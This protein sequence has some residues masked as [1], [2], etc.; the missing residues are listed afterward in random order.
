M[1]DEHH[2]PVHHRSGANTFVRTLAAS[3]PRLA[4]ALLL[5]FGCLT[6]AARADL[7]A[8]HSFYVELD[9]SPGAKLPRSFQGRFEFVRVPGNERLRIRSEDARVCFTEA[10]CLEPN[11][12]VRG[13]TEHRLSRTGNAILLRLFA[14]RPG[15]PVVIH[16]EDNPDGQRALLHS[17]LELYEPVGNVAVGGKMIGDFRLWGSWGTARAGR[18]P[19]ND[20]WKTWLPVDRPLHFDRDL[21]GDVH[22]TVEDDGD[23]FVRYEA[24]AS[25]SCPQMEGARAVCERLRSLGIGGTVFSL[26][27]EWSFDE[28]NEGTVNDLVAL[29]AAG[30]WGEN[31]LE[32]ELGVRGIESD[33][34]RLPFARLRAADLSTVQARLVDPAENESPVSPPNVGPTLGQ[35]LPRPHATQLVHRTGGLRMELTLEQYE[36]HL[37]DTLGGTLL[38]H[39]EDCPTGS[40]HILSSVCRWASDVQPAQIDLALEKEV[41]QSGDSRGTVSWVGTGTPYHPAARAS[42]AIEVR[43]GPNLGDRRVVYLRHG[44]RKDSLVFA[45]VPDASAPDA[46]LAPSAFDLGGRWLV[47]ASDPDLDFALG[48]RDLGGGRLSVAVRARN[49]V[50]GQIEAIAVPDRRGSCFYYGDECFEVVRDVKGTVDVLGAVGF[51]L[52]DPDGRRIVVRSTQST[53]PRLDAGANSASM[54]LRAMRD[55][56]SGRDTLV[57]RRFGRSATGLAGTYRTTEGELVLTERALK[58]PDGSVA[59]AGLD[60]ER[61][62]AI[63]I[64]PQRTIGVR[65]IELS[66]NGA[67]APDVLIEMFRTSETLGE[68]GERW[69]AK[70]TGGLALPILTDA[71][72]QRFASFLTPAQ[73]DWLQFR[74]DDRPGLEPWRVADIDRLDQPAGS[75]SDS[76]ACRFYPNQNGYP[77]L[78]CQCRDD[79]GGGR[80]LFTDPDA[81]AIDP[82]L[83]GGERLHNRNGEVHC[84]RPPRFMATLGGAC[85][86]VNLYRA[87][88]NAPNELRALCEIEHTLPSRSRQSTLLSPEGCRAVVVENARLVCRHSEGI[89][90]TTRVDAARAR[91]TEVADEVRQ[92]F[93]P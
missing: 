2:R 14:N 52:R 50:E 47:N 74:L 25:R 45:A 38:V 44:G 51:V 37:Q 53:T 11:Q 64:D 9:E 84:R 78:T 72:W 91:A 46:G 30:G 71:G 36:A 35:T 40:A 32:I 21:A 58:L 80:G 57:A 65:L 26:A 1:I 86:Q 5:T 66:V 18:V 23:V 8:A 16:L 69:T 75:Y 42:D 27:P 29:R 34:R 79:R 92:P 82:V 88:R 73:H 7:E 41:A 10:L 90:S 31:A 12:W 83:C 49:L 22:V 33:D 17:D 89:E 77:V 55:D 68:P 70:R 61:A 60:E 85:S 62:R 3:I 54:Q 56:V 28:P 13:E 63:V 81:K 87:H 39:A 48:I 19:A 15:G 93:R 6:S 4:V 67:V 76:C 24:D 20:A 59:L 43:L